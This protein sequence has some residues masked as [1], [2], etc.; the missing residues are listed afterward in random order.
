MKV[1]NFGSLNIDHVYRLERFVRPGETTECRDYRR[2]VG[3]K[4]ANQSV[5]L[6]RAGATVQH[7]GRI[8]AD[9]VWLAEYMAESGVDTHLIETVAAPSGHAVIQV[10]DTGENSIVLYGGA[11]RSFT[12]EYIERVL[13]GART[14]DWVLLQNETNLVPEMIV[15]AAAAGCR[16]VFNPAPMSP[17]VKGCALDQLSVLVVNEIE[18]AALSGA[19]TPALMLGGLARLCP[20]ALVVVTLGETGVIAI[21]DG[22]RFELPAEPVTPLDTTAAG[23]TFV[24]YLT[25]E[26][27][28]GTSPAAALT[29][30]N[31]AAAL[32]VQRPGAADSIPKLAELV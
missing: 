13:A 10:T 24:G 8:G 26:L 31:R 16:V 5:A 6:A 18:G 15:L 3:G 27:A 23:D 32:C 14:G 25:A 4:G 17:L 22:E 2:G 29:I 28:R 12:A 19:E 9:G 7:A 1:I 21:Q 20:R 30:A 11:N